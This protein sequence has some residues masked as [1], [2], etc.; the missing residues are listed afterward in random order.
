MTD[1][2]ASDWNDGL[3]PRIQNDMPTAY[4]E[5]VFPT[6]TYQAAE[7]YA[8]TEPLVTDEAP[9]IMVPVDSLSN[10]EIFNKLTGIESRL[11]AMALLL[12]SESTPDMIHEQL[13]TINSR[14]AVIELTQEALKEGTNTI[15]TMMNG[16]SEAFANIMEQ[17]QKGGI[18][19]LL[20]GMMGKK[21][22]A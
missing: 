12:S 9:P 14:L 20:G 19:G 22:D 7:N 16:V 8:L 3:D 6:N 5:D 21:N 10:M 2:D 1:Q 15:G 11:A 4:G 18:G 13:I 17:I